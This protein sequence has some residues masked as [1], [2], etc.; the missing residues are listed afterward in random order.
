[1]DN[2][3]K[4]QE[5]I[6]AYV[7]SKLEEHYTFDLWKHTLVNCRNKQL[8][9]AIDLW[10][11][12][13]EKFFVTNLIPDVQASSN[14]WDACLHIDFNWKI[15]DKSVHVRT[16]LVN[17]KVLYVQLV[18]MLGLFETFGETYDFASE[19]DA[20]VVFFGKLK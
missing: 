16:I 9:Q 10:N 18:D 20:K 14:K 13:D 15:K 6:Q 8:K 17:E 19:F 7:D 11:F 3:V 5:H 12:F 2:I 1:M 4:L